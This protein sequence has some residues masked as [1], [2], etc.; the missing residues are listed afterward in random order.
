MNNKKLPNWLYHIYGLTGLIAFFMMWWVL[1]LQIPEGFFQQFT[2]NSTLLKLIGLV[3]DPETYT[4]IA[5]S[6]KRIFI[7]LFYALLIGIPIGLL[8]GQNQKADA[9]SSQIFQ[10]LRMISPLSWMPIAVMILGVGDKPIYFLLAFAAVWPIILNTATGVK[11][12]CNVTR[13]IAAYYLAKC[14]WANFSWFTSC[15]WNR[16]DC[17]C[18]K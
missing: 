4:H 10:F 2:L 17:A 13:S 7:G 6:L 3:Q 14:S 1:G 16:L 15:D 9:F 12:R 18:P 8:I 5:M 11:F